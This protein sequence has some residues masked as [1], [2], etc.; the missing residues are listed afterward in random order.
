MKSRGLLRRGWSY[1]ETVEHVLFQCIRYNNERL[2]NQIKS[3]GRNS[4]S[5]QSLLRNSLQV[6]KRLLDFLK[7]TNLIKII[8]SYYWLIDFSCFLFTPHWCSTLHLSRRQKC[9][10]RLLANRHQIKR[11]RRKGWRK[12]IKKKQWDK[13]REEKAAGFTKLKG[14]WDRCEVQGK[15]GEKM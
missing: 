12:R 2:K 15:T 6:S 1:P 8:L 10:K 13:K 3:L 14:K 11:R 9:T 5:L 7:S 4:L